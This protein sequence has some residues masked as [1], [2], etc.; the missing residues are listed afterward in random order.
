MI[1]EVDKENIEALGSA[2]V[3]ESIRAAQERVERVFIS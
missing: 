3:D 1:Y 2:D